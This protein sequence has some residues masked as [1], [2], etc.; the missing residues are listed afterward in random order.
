[1]PRASEASTKKSWDSH[2][3]ALVVCIVMIF[4]FMCLIIL[5]IY[6]TPF[7]SYFPVK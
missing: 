6:Q 4:L 3:I 1:M 7:I 5:L 2:S